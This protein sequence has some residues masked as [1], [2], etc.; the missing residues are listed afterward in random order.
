MQAAPARARAVAVPKGLSQAAAATSRSYLGW[1]TTAVKQVLNAGGAFAGY[2]RASLAAPT[3]RAAKD[4]RA[5]SKQLFPLPLQ[6][7]LRLPGRMRSRHGYRR[8]AEAPATQSLALLSGLA[9]N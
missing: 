2:C 4:A 9:L 5:V 6:S 8:W 7:L 3:T 1:A